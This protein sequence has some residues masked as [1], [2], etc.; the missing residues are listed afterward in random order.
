MDISHGGGGE[1]NRKAPMGCEK[2][3]WAP[4]GVKEI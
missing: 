4:M 1:R 2:N 3:R